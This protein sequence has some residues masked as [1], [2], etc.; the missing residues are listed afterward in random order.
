VVLSDPELNKIGPE[1]R[2]DLRS[3]WFSYSLFAHFSNS[4]LAF[5]PLNFQEV[6]NGILIDYH[7]STT[8]INLTEKSNFKK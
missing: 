2:I 8:L 4:S 7:L 5:P 6:T 3:N 1:S